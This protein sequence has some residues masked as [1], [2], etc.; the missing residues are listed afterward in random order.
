MNSFL[1]LIEKYIISLDPNPRPPTSSL[2]IESLSLWSLSLWDLSLERLNLEAL[3]LESLCLWGLQLRIFP[4]M[5]PISGDQ[6]SAQNSSKIKIK[7]LDSLLEIDFYSLT[8]IFSCDYSLTL[9]EFFV[10]FLDWMVNS[11]TVKV[12]PWQLVSRI[13]SIFS[14]SLDCEHVL[15]IASEMFSNDYKYYL[16]FMNESQYK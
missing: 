7:F 14:L 2:G 3:S 10:F 4:S 5:S 1:R 6:L 16:L 8:V 11:L 12:K 13:L 15:N 9:L